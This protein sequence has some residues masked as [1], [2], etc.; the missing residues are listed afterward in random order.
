MAKYKIVCSDLDGT[1]VNSQSNISAEN[2]KAIE[3]MA[4]KGAFFVPSTGR[5][6]WDLPNELR[7]NEHIRYFICSNGAVVFDKH[8]KQSHLVGIRKKL[9]QE[10]FAIL[11][12]YEVHLS[13]RDSGKCYVDERY[14]NDEAFD[15]YNVFA[16]HRAVV[17]E[18]ALR[19]KDFAPFCDALTKVEA[20]SAS[21]HDRAEMLAARERLER[22]GGLRVVDASE[23]MLEI[24][25]VEAGKGNALL[26][27]CEHLGVSREESIGVGDSDNDSTML[28]AAG[29]GLAVSNACESL[30]ETAD[31]IICSNDEHAIK[32]IENNFLT[33]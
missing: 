21:F 27:L 33:L 9:S 5:A 1:L 4:E 18:F 31:E 10:I 13:V 20:I 12:S 3:L 16:A 25:N 17:S 26:W 24:V 22:L 23:Y 28:C 7:N 6:F 32:Y 30:K 15:Y 19:L 11:R 2:L 14:I 29:L 8:T